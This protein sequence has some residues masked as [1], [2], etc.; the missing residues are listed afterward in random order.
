MK[1]TRATSC[2]EREHTTESRFLVRAKVQRLVDRHC[3][4]IP[5]S[6][7]LV[8]VD[9]YHVKLARILSDEL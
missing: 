6:P 5:G 7:L 2:P 3:Y 4:S 9:E 1:E 8:G